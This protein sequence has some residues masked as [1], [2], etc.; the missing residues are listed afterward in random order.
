MAKHGA[1][2][3]KRKTGGGIAGERRHSNFDA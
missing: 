2:R 1:Q 3:W